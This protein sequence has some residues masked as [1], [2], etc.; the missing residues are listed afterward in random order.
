MIKIKILRFD[1][2]EDKVPYFESYEIEET[3][4]MKI[5]DAL[6]YINQTYN[7]NLAFRSSCRA[8]QCGSC[9]LKIDGGLA[10]ACKDEIHNGAKLEPLD[11]P[12]IKDLIV[13]RS[14]INEKIKS[15]NLY[16]DDFDDLNVDNDSKSD[17][18]DFSS[19]KVSLNNANNVVNSCGCLNIIPDSECFNTKKVRSC[20]ECFSCLS[21]CPVLDIE[22]VD[23]I[24]EFAGPFFMRYLSK[25]A[26]DP[27]DT[28]EKTEESVEEGLYCCTSC[29]K[30][31]EV[32][33]KNINTFGDAIEKL[34]A[35]AYRDDLGPL[36][37]HKAVKALIEKTGRSV[38]VDGESLIYLVNK[39]TKSPKEKTSSSKN[40]NKTIYDKKIGIFTG[41]MV[42]YR[43]QNVGL[44]L[45]DVLDN[46]GIEADFVKDQVCCGSPL[47]RTGQVDI[48]DKLVNQNRK[49]FE[50]YD[51]ILTVCA[52]CGATL[53]EDYPKYGVNLNVMDISEFLVDVVGIGAIKSAFRANSEI[54][55]KTNSKTTNNVPVKV[56][57][58]DPCHLARGQGIREAPRKILNAIESVDFIEMEKPNQCCGAGGGVRS[59]KPYIAEALAR[60]KAKMAKDTGADAV[61]TICPFCQYNIQDG[62]DKEGMSNIK[63]LNIL[64]LLKKCYENGNH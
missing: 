61:I 8:G 35:L 15:M 52:G 37:A 63:V 31:G 58:H 48:V 49:V 7:A 28:G 2:K 27:R 53:K 51:I 29:G 12:V 14:E 32:C 60:E 26:L 64:E 9:S 47:I 33:P 3:P 16:L 4:K 50:D 42:D 13:D 19:N 1:R 17:S 30:C 10:L 36:E 6:N 45:K 20:I 44:A 41:C 54:N 38:D 46:L 5:L 34:R 25:F 24:G 11:F 55:S 43:L 22:G 18:E 21:A 39:E 62:L 56:S 23:E 57:Y 40:T 59:G